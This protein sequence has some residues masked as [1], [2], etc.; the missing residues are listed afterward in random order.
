MGMYLE[1]KEARIGWL[2]N[3][4]AAASRLI[5]PA[6]AMH[7]P[8]LRSNAPRVF[9]S[10]L[11]CSSCF[12]ESWKSNL[13]AN[14][15][16]YLSLL[17][18]YFHL[19]RIKVCPGL[20]VVMLENRFQFINNISVWLTGAWANMVNKSPASP[21][22][23]IFRLNLSSRRAERSSACASGTYT[24]LIGSSS[25]TSSPAIHQLGSVCLPHIGEILQHRSGAAGCICQPGFE[26]PAGAEFQYALLRSCLWIQLRR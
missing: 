16:L 5:A 13:A 19:M 1:L 23:S 24:W 21:T 4:P 9:V 3:Q 8:A 17:Q 15:I 18:K 20:N 7:M 14:K 22:N 26:I 11:K 12:H 2:N 10:V 6:T 25:T